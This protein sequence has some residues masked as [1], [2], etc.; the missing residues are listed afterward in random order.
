[1]R[2][3]VNRS[4]RDSNL[5]R[6]G[7]GYPP[8][9]AEDPEDVPLQSDLPRIPLRGHY[10][11][12]ARLRRLEFLRQ[13]T[14]APLYS[15]QNTTLVPERLSKN[16]EQMIGAVELPVGVAGPLLFAGRRARGLVYA[17]MA[18]TEGAL[19]ASATR[20]AKAISLSTGAKTEVLAQRMTRVPAFLFSDL[21]SASEFCRWIRRH[22][23]ELRRWVK[24][25]SAHAELV[26][27]E[28]L[29]MAHQVHAHFV[30]E[31]GDAAGQN[32]TTA[33]TW[34]I[35]QRMQELGRTE[36]ALNFDRF[37]IDGNG[38]TDKKVSFRSFL[39]GR[40]MRA[41]AE[42]FIP[43]KTLEKVLK[44]SPEELHEIV[45][46]ARDGAIA[47][48][49]IGFN[50]N[51]SNMVA[52][53]FTATGQDIAC[54]HESSVAHLQTQVIDD[55]LSAH[56][57]LPSLIVGTV[58]GGTHL[59][60]Q[61]E[62]LQMLGCVG[63]DSAE[64]LAE[65]IAGFSLA[66]DLSTAAAVASGAFAQA[67]ERLGRNR[68]V[69][70]LERKEID[71]AFFTEPLRASLGDSTLEVMSAA[72]LPDRSHGQSILTELSA[73]KVSKLVGFFPY[74]LEYRTHGSTLSSEVMVK[75]KPTD[76]EVLLM[77]SSIAGLCGRAVM[78]AYAPCRRLTG[79]AGCHRRELALYEVVDPRM[80]FHTPRVFGILR[81]E[82]REIYGLILER[83]EDVI[84]L[85][86][87]DDPSGWRPE[88]VEAALR[89]IAAVHSIWYGRESELRQASWLGNPMTTELMAK[90]APLWSSLADH[91]RDEFPE[92]FTEDDLKRSQAL[93]QGLRFWW[94]DLER[95]P[96]T[97]VHN[98]FNPRNIALRREE[99]GFRLCAYDWE[100]AAIHP[101]G[102]DLAE[103]L[104][105]LLTP[106]ATRDEIDHYVEV[107]RRALESSCGF[108]ID[109]APFRQGYRLSLRDL[110]VNRF[111]MY[112]MAHAFRHYGFL[113]RS[114][115][116]LRRLLDLE[117]SPASGSS[118]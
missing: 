63:E 60:R 9:S 4:D 86:T 108:P 72:P 49:A 91:A 76:D 52:A 70:G 65:I 87:A 95:L 100:L 58:G 13:E 55:G 92:W 50:I 35:C 20:G 59:E 73:R 106:S 75:L 6:A 38:S 28:P 42:C 68:P 96:R 39:A 51:V 33:A 34:H 85:D 93:I 88:H 27:C 26:S 111:A 101:P 1:M 84:L 64:R 5:A 69:R 67:H 23:A 45:G 53:L 61:N 97:L 22:F 113:E 48:G 21:R 81:D 32:M 77:V 3:S 82:A 37:F 12:A 17:P 47:S 98:D 116:T 29:I 54:V 15:L 30:Y 44:T 56:L 2:D 10:D 57:Q 118:C 74:R 25:V 99:R 102:H 110:W 89:G 109:A 115:A 43:R 18:T 41:V 14:A 104:C 7:D 36:A 16:I 11:E 94:S 103:L 66:L 80:R 114:F 8:G 19:V 105:F 31:T 62:L 71:A 79:F 40:G 83:L 24:E 112:I 90:M 117:E 78:D 107:H 46:I